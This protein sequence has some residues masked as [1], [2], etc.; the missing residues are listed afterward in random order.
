M[1][2]PLSAKG[3]QVTILWTPLHP[4]R[5]RKWFPH[6]LEQELGTLITAPATQNKMHPKAEFTVNE[7]HSTC[8]Q[9]HG[10][11]SYSRMVKTPNVHLKMPCRTQGVV[12]PCLGRGCARC[13]EGRMRDRALRGPGWRGLW[14]NTQTWAPGN[15]ALRLTQVSEQK[16]LDFHV[17][18]SYSRYLTSFKTADFISLTVFF[19]PTV[20]QH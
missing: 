8:Q 1:G 18:G 14:Q 20:R 6:G 19:N 11:H 13:G 12:L 7:W 10:T 16:H 5:K 17:D 3:L 15:A 4:E 2:S 9:L